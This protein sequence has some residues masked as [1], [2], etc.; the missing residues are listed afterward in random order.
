MHEVTK[1]D[2][3]DRARHAITVVVNRFRLTGDADLKICSRKFIFHM[4]IFPTISISPGS[5]M[6]CGTDV[7]ATRILNILKQVSQFKLKRSN[8][9]Y[10]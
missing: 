8:P 7:S 2:T 4:N 5:L 6:G 3:L 1:V 10:V 9:N